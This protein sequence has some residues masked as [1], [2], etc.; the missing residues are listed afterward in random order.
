MYLILNTQSSNPHH[1]GDCAYA[2][3]ELTPA[4]VKR[5]R[6][7]VALARKVAKQDSDLYEM[8]FWGSNAEFFDQKLLG[9]CEKAVAFACGI[10]AA[11]DWRHNL[12]E[13]GYA[14]MPADIDLA[15]HEAQRTEVDQMLVR[16]S[17]Y[18]R[19]EFSVAWMASPKYAD[20][21]VTTSELPIAVMDE[22]LANRG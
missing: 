17:R 21:D 5:I 15:T 18:R 11:E 20:L 14:V 19:P 6:G 13:T 2:V 12:E 4:L 7:R 22:L 3:V 10:Q 9:T 1:N 16:C 8:C